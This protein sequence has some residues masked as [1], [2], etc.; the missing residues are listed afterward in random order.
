VVIREG[1][2]VYRKALRVEERW[3]SSFYGAVAIP[4]ALNQYTGLYRKLVTRLLEDPEF[5]AAIKR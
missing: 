3:V 5:V 1:R 2:E 4:M